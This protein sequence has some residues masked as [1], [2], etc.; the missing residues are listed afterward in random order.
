[1]R[2]EISIAHKLPRADSCTV[3]YEIEFLIHIVE[4]FEVDI[5]VDFTCFAKPRG[6]IIEINCRVHQ[7]DGEREAAF[8]R[9][10]RLDSL[11]C[12]SLSL[13]PSCPCRGFPSRSILDEACP[14]RG[15]KPRDNRSAQRNRPIWNWK[16]ACP[17][18]LACLDDGDT[19][20]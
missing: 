14:E 1:M 8:K 6:Q 16:V 3:D 13:R 9:F 15:R 12:R 10:E 7:R 4:V 17:R 19:A 2:L 11:T 20:R 5:R 18:K